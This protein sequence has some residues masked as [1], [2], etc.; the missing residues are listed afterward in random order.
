MGDSAWE[1]PVRTGKYLFLFGIKGKFYH[2]ALWQRNLFL[3]LKLWYGLAIVISSHLSFYPKFGEENHLQPSWAMFK[4]LLKMPGENS[5]LW[6]LMSTTDG[7]KKLD[8]LPNW[9]VCV[10]HQWLLYLIQVCFFFFLWSL[11]NWFLASLFG[12]RA[13]ALQSGQKIGTMLSNQM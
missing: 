1:V 9:Y 4:R 6:H 5:Q 13:E 3:E 10:S 12:N 8:W 7:S 2:L 11:L